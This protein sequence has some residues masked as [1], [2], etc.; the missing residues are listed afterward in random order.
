V[1]SSAFPYTSTLTGHDFK[2]LISSEFVSTRPHKFPSPN[3]EHLIVILFSVLLLYICSRRFA[4]DCASH[5]CLNLLLHTTRI[6]PCQA[7]NGAA[8]I[9]IWNRNK[10]VMATAYSLLGINVAFFIHSMSLSFSRPTGDLDSNRN[11]VFATGVARV[12]NPFR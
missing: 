12:N 5:V 1:Q 6:S 11:A 3:T 7:L 8:S 10:F 4:I 9:A 2:L